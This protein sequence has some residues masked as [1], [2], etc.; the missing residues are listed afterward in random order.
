MSLLL[1]MYDF[2]IF[3]AL[4]SETCYLVFLNLC[5]FVFLQIKRKLPKVNRGLAARLLEDEDAENEGRDIDNGDTKKIS[6]KKKGLTSE[7]MKDDRF[8]AMFENKV[9]LHFF[10]FD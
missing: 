6:K 10:L 1:E 9:I 7:V 2:E 5:V 3:Y 8:A 4:V